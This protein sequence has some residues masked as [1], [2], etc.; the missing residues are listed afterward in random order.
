MVFVTPTDNRKVQPT[1]KKNT[2][3]S[4]VCREDVK[5]TDRGSAS[6]VKNKVLIIGDSHA[7]NCVTRL[8][9][10]LSSEYKVSSYIK[11]GARM[12]EITKTARE[13]LKSLKCEDLVIV[14]GGANDIG[15]NNTKEALK[16]LLDFVIEHKDLKVV[17]LNSSHRHDL[18]PHSCIN[19]EVKKFNRKLNKI[20]K[21]HSKVKVMELE[22]D[23]NHFTRHG[24]HLNSEG[25]KLVSQKLAMV[26]QNFAIKHQSG[27]ISATWK[28]HPFTDTNS[29]TQEP[30]NKEGMNSSTSSSQ[31]KK[32]SC[33]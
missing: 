20:M 13:E 16:L 3:N 23:R 29:T 7:R 18:L 26:V 27:T 5:N 22:L 24:L 12:S 25:K 10:N 1:T 21:L 28:V 4:I 8:Q 17:V 14:W 32:L 15:K 31:H 30:S 19:L 9:D 11:P 6:K 2:Q 33:L